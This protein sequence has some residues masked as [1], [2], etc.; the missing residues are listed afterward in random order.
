MSE[1]RTVDR[2]SSSFDSSLA[3]SV[4]SSVA[5]L[6]LLGALAVGCAGA[7]F[8]PPPPPPFKVAVAVE[9]D[10]GQP[11]L[12][13]V[14]SRNERA[15]ATTGA[16]GRAELTLEGA[17][18]ETIDTTVKCPVGH[19]SPQK[20]V[21]MRLARTNGGAP[22]VFKVSCP[23]TERHVVVAV[24]AENG[25]NLPVLYLGRVVAHTDGSGAAHFEVVAPP[26]GQFQVT[27]DT[28]AK[29]FAKLKP[30]SPS[31]PFTIGQ[32]DDI[33]VFEQKFEVEKKKVAKVK[34]HV[35]GCLSCKT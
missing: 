20:P 27:L 22:P 24:K 21:T 15:L 30:Q 34:P 18:G 32:G 9:G 1:T 33:L 26:G 6:P 35:P 5:A 13:A 12:G 23:P 28:T 31:K 4:A 3:S 8:D 25:P 29:E 7:T 14:V 2:V 17:D 10:P 16:D 11:I 19:T